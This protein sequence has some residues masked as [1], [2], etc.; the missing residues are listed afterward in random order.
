VLIAGEP[1]IGKTRLMAEAA[2]A[3]HDEGAA[4]LYGRCEEE[5]GVPYQ[6]FAEAL[7][8]YVELGPQPVL[9]AHVERRGGELIRLV[10]ELAGRV[11]VPAPPDTNPEAEQ[12]LL[13]G[14]MVDLLERAA[15]DAPVVLVLDDLHWADKPSLVF[16]R[17][18]LAS[19]DTTRL[20]VLGAYREGD[21]G[22]DHPL[23]D[24][25][26]ALRREPGVDRVALDGLDDEDLVELLE[27]SG[28]RALDEDGVALA[29]TLRRETK[30]N[31][32]FVAEVLRHLADTGTIAQ[33][34]DGTWAGAQDLADVGLPQS[35]REVVGRRVARL[36]DAAQR[37]LSVAAVIG[38]DFD[39]ELLCRVSDRSEDELLDVLDEARGAALI[40]D[41]AERSDRF[42]FAHGLI[43]QSLAEDLS[44]ARRQRLHRRVAE[45]LEEL[46]AGNPGARVGELAEH[47]AKATVP[48]D[49]AKAISYAR[50]AG[51][52]AL[53]QLAPDDAVGWY[54]QAL[55]IMDRRHADDGARCD[56]LIQLANAQ[57][58]AGDPKHEETVAAAA[59]LARQLGS[60]DRFVSAVLA[61]ERT[62]GM[63]NR[64]R[65]GLGGLIEEALDQLGPA[66]SAARS[67][68]LAYLI[69]TV[70]EYER[71][72]EL[73]EESIAVARR[74]GD[75]WVL[76]HALLRAGEALQVPTTLDSRL[77][78]SDEAVDLALASGD[79]LTQI[80]AYEIRL[81]ASADRGDVATY[82]DTL[83]AYAA[84]S[85][86]FS[87]PETE[88]DLASQ[89]TWRALAAGRL[90][91][92]ERAIERMRTRGERIGYPASAVQ[93]GAT[94]LALRRYQ[95]RL[96]EVVDF[97][98]QLAD[99]TRDVRYAPSL[100]FARAF[101]YAELDDLES[102]AT[103]FDE[104]WAG[105]GIALIPYDQSWLS[106]LNML[107]TLAAAL[108]RR[109][110]AEALYRTLAPWPDRVV[111]I[112]NGAGS[113]SHTLGLLAM[114]LGR[115]DA[116]AA[117]LAEARRTHERIDAPYWAAQ[118]R[119][120]EAQLLA[121]R[122]EPDTATA[123]AIAQEV[124][125]AA[126]ARGFGT[127]ERRAAA[128]IGAYR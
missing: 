122:P 102:A 29:H 98:N 11:A 109:D 120:A 93:A 9:A 100:A 89:Q 128:L 21:L 121:T 59:D 123:R 115:F 75:P 73:A 68:L 96:L 40:E 112:G 71:R 124:L 107:A 55:G 3:F 1:G 14:A 101:M 52:Y 19:L 31:P 86:R 97:L 111:L 63:A 119:L 41:V 62:V 51:D 10:P 49:T 85:E 23:V 24:V 66:D 2:A 47:W 6:P 83:A 80:G 8:R 37:V 44:A 39:L 43:A 33:Q 79:P 15:A 27:V 106:T 94:E 84:V 61:G 90:E 35:I 57:R 7:R 76:C 17:H 104:I 110:A 46:T 25:L 50:Q 118:T 87:M 36:G 125:D 77:A 82:D 53:E 127:L 117:H 95:G 32:F 22:R 108:E 26:A 16:L 81:W 99:D 105:G 74:V 34:A 20:L 58:W 13:F 116:A 48:A 65:P 103:L 56:V 38:R 5:L 69:T 113:V 12:Y 126:R 78:W 28:G 88:L 60:A 114:T 54:A 30:G 4:V 92:A 45:A 18:L 72:T 70:D 67:R 91:E 64:W 42:A